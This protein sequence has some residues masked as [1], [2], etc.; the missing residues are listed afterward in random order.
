MDRMVEYFVKHTD[1][2]FDQLRGEIV[3]LEE[4]VDE[5]ITFKVQMVSSAKG[6]AFVMSAI[7]GLVT[8][9]TTVLTVYAMVKK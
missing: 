6:S 9:V 4:K 5:L 2:R 1:E 8:F 3:K 7:A